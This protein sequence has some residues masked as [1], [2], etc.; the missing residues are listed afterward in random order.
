MKLIVLVDMIRHG[1]FV[2]I[3]DYLKHNGIQLI[4]RDLF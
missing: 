1:S 4:F 3:A 2:F